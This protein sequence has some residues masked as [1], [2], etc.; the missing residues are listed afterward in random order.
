MELLVH[1]KNI[2]VTEALKAHVEKKIGKLS[3]F[4]NGVQE[5]QVL[6][7]VERGQHICEVTVPL[8][9]AV[10]RGEAR[11]N[12]M[13]GA[14]DEVV[15]K[16]ERQIRRY[17]ARFAHAGKGF[18]FVPAKNVDSKDEIVRQKKFP[19]KPM[20]PDEAVMQM[21][22]VGHDFFVFMNAETESV[23]VIYRRRD[24]RYGLLEPD[25]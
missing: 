15:E 13:Y 4:W 17:K 20:D 19:L 6:L 25:V 9:G 21:N 3:R 23:N 5:A 8:A 1:G 2:P 10:L 14:V 7:Q 12:D 24:G 11:T 16:L 22:L 18:P